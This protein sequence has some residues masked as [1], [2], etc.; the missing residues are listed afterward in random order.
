MYICQ[1]LVMSDDREEQNP[2]I[3]REERRLERVRLV[4]LL[5]PRDDFEDDDPGPAAA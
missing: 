5:P 4:A 2:E 1:A 3:E